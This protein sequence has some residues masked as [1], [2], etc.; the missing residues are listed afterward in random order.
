[1]NLKLQDQYFNISS[2]KTFRK[3]VKSKNYVVLGSADLSEGRGGIVL[4]LGVPP[5]RPYLRTEK[6]RYA[7]YQHYAFQIFGPFAIKYCILII[8]LY[9]IFNRCYVKAL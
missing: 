6:K 8:C 3:F 1:M 7:L 5:L 2:K 9:S 4:V